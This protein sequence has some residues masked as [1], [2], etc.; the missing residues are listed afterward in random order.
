MIVEI[1]PLSE[2]GIRATFPECPRCD[3]PVNLE[4][5]A[6]NEQTVCPHCGSNVLLV[7]IDGI[8]MLLRD[9]WT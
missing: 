2:T 9:G 7:R 3:Q 4:G 8:L 1:Q 5:V 6:L